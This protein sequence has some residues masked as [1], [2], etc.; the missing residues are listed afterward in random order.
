MTTAQLRAIQADH[1]PEAVAADPAHPVCTT[2]CRF[3]GTR[4]RRTPWPCHAAR[5]A[6]WLLDQRALPTVQ[7]LE[8]RDR[9]RGQATT[10]AGSAAEG[11]RRAYAELFPE[12]D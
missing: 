2:C 3:D 1:Q 4:A 5:L 6:A 10:G 7:D 12:E 11:R 8:R 9:E